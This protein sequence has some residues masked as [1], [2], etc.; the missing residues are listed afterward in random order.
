MM[1]DT[2]K[3]KIFPYKLRRLKV[4]LNKIIIIIIIIMALILSMLL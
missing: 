4:T 1:Y 2:I 3:L